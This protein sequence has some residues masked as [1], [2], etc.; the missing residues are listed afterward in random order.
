MPFFGFNSHSKKSDERDQQ[1]HI[2]PAHPHELY[3]QIDSLQSEMSH[4]YMQIAFMKTNN[5]D[6]LGRPGKREEMTQQALANRD[7]TRDTVPTLSTTWY[8]LDISSQSCKERLHRL[9]IVSRNYFSM[10]SLDDDKHV[11]SACRPE[12]DRRSKHRKPPPLPEIFVPATAL[13]EERSRRGRHTRRALDDDDDDDN[14]QELLMYRVRPTPGDQSLE[15]SL[16]L[17]DVERLHAPTKRTS[18]KSNGSKTVSTTDPSRSSKSGGSSLQSTGVVRYRTVKRIVKQTEILEPKP[19]DAAKVSR[20]SRLTPTQ[21]GVATRSV[22][23]AER[24]AED[25][26]GRMGKS[27]PLMGK[28]N[29]YPPPP[30][31]KENPLP[32]PR[33][34][35]TQTSDKSSSNIRLRGSSDTIPLPREIRRREMGLLQPATPRKVIE[36]KRRH[37]IQGMDAVIAELR[38]GVTLK[39][40]YLRVYPRTPKK[41]CNP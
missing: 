22:P 1:Q 28:T 20:I 12:V 37:F 38:K 34:R 13:L 3:A 26:D 5:G 11:A 4:L 23:Y 36:Q 10:H 41:S 8:V 32:M 40:A 19:E 18:G 25:E 29:N 14:D 30:K 31:V 6:S 17:H 2:A 39:P 21:R 7:T 9:D 16:L 27:A 35:T 15:S 33:M 24:A